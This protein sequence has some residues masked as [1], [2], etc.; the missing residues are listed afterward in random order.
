MSSQ[1]NGRAGRQRWTEE[2]LQSALEAV[3][4]G[5]S[6]KSA[7]SSNG[8]PRKTLSDYIK[9]GEGATKRRTGP[10]TVFSEEQE[11]DLVSRI[12]RLQKVGFPLSRD[13]IRR[14]AY[15]AASSLEL[16]GRFGTSAR[17]SQR[18]GK[19]WFKAFMNRHKDLSTR[20]TETL[21]YGRG[22]GLNRVV[23]TGFFDLLAKTISEECIKPQNIFNM[24]ETGVQLTT[25]KGAVIAEKGSKRVPQLSSGEKG[26]TVS[27]VAC[28]SATG[29]F[30]PPL[31][32]YKG[33]RRKDELADDL[34]SGSEFC[35]TDSG[36]A[37]TQTFLSFVQFFCKHK[38]P[39]KTLLIMDGHRSHIDADAF[40]M[41]D[42]EN[43]SI[44]LLPAHTSHE[45]QPLDKAVFKSLKT[46]FYMQSKAWHCQ[47]PGRSLSKL[48]FS[49]VFTPAWNKAATRENAVAGF[50]ATGIFPLNPLAI[51]ESSFGPSDASD[52]PNPSEVVTRPM[53]TELEPD[54]RGSA[55]GDMSLEMNIIYAADA[56]SSISLSD[57]QNNAV[58]PSNMTTTEPTLHM[59]VDVF[60][61]TTHDEVSVLE[62]GPSSLSTPSRTSMLSDQLLLQSDGTRPIPQATSTPTPSAA[63]CSDHEQQHTPMKANFPPA[64][65]A[66]DVLF[67][68]LLTT[69]KTIRKAVNAK[70]S[71]N[72]K[73]VVL[74]KEMV[75]PS[76]CKDAKAGRK[77]GR[78]GK[79]PKLMEQVDVGLP[80]K[81]VAKGQKSSK[82]RTCRLDAGRKVSDYPRAPKVSTKSSAIPCCVCGIFEDSE[83]DK[84]LA[85]DWIQCMSCNSWCHE[86]C[87]ESG[88][89]FDDDFFT[90]PA[91]AEKL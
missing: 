41:A 72:N 24:D 19:D 13:D 77:V 54:A 62:S 75:K 43:I 71:T 39:G 79:N 76:K 20:T 47:H 73:A 22:A 49:Q 64:T 1:I 56:D 55:D 63:N 40:R 36:Y 57:H 27:V 48:S 58:R 29:V 83:E 12:K 10:A 26:E 50:Q 85:Q 46:A 21:S 65:P 84:R 59:S 23:V 60:D 82:K 88:G 74:T 89:I 18:A 14:T 61:S 87:G 38:P 32:I 35:M 3:Q 25:R 91:C 69:P 2:A 33:V 45:L 4:D 8:I 44:L 34:P 70:R 67:R 90:C 30:L 78:K 81:S 11:N 86:I 7:A 68:S 15:Q 51:S 80:S 52:R 37:Q 17:A 53:S 42:D 28:C 31:V 9:R 16:T 6:I 5:T 66:S